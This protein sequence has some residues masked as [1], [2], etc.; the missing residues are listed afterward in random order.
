[1]IE[2][3]MLAACVLVFGVHIAVCARVSWLGLRELIRE[4][5]ALRG[6][7][8]ARACSTTPPLQPKGAP[9]SGRHVRVV[10]KT[11]SGWEPHALVREGTP[12]WDKAW[13]DETLAFQEPDGTIH[14]G[15]QQ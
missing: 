3:L 8:A 2:V 13:A 4:L 15:A 11:A 1:M 12:A 9:P 6:E 7:L 5:K 14:R 10:H